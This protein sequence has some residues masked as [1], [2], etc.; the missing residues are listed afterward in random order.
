MKIYNLPS[1]EQWAEVVARPTFDNSQLRE[2]VSGLL[3]QI[4][5]GG[6]EVLK[7][8][9]A[10]F[11]HCTLDQLEVQPSEFDEAIV[12]IRLGRCHLSCLKKYCPIP[13]VSA[14]NIREGGDSAGCDLLAEG[15]CNR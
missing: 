13:R 8:L 10:K 4:R 5:E 15:Y 11:D 9:E 3:T 1:R 2:L 12:N 7:E 6:D 14:S